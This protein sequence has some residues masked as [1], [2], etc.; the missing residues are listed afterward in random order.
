MTT[1]PYYVYSVRSLW[2][3]PVETPAAI[4]AKLLNMLDALSATHS[5]FS[6][7]EISDFQN[8]SSG[9]EI[10]DILNV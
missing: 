9:D 7:W 10:T 5:I 2:N 1:E 3:G 6:D 8:P 4:G